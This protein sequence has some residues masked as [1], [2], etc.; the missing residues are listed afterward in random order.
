MYWWRIDERVNY[1]SFY[2]LFNILGPDTW[3]NIAP[4]GKGKRQSP[5]D[6]NL[7]TVTFD[8]SLNTRPLKYV[9]D[10]SK[11]DKLLNNGKSAQVTFNSEGS[12]K[13]HAHTY[14]YQ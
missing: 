8:D 13:K 14:T 10:A 4:A 2:N 11:A 12:G 9:Y 1:H 6:I 5:I 7:S 3:S